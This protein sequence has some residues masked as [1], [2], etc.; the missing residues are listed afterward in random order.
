MNLKEFRARNSRQPVLCGGK[1]PWGT[2]EGECMY[3]I[4]SEGESEV[5]CRQTQGEWRGRDLTCL[6][7]ARH[8]RAPSPR[9]ATAAQRQALHGKLGARG[10]WDR[11][12][13]T[14]SKWQSGDKNRH[15]TPE[16]MLLLLYCST[17]NATS[18]TKKVSISF[19]THKRHC[20][21]PPYF[22]F[23]SPL[24]IPQDQR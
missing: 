4:P 19:F 22:Y 20:L 2:N 23:M 3:S 14:D 24:P 5:S 8:A 11:T 12:S 10:L 17:I 13:Y 15:L 7:R 16:F 21:H 9:T 1:E 18:S 6:C